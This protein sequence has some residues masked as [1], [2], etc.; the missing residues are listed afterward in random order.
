MKMSCP[1]SESYCVLP[2]TVVI[3]VFPVEDQLPVE[4]SGSHRWL[5]V[6]ET[7]VVYITQAH[8][9][10]S[11]REDPDADLTY[12]ITRPCFSPLRP[13]YVSANASSHAR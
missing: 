3:H 5:T 2:Q 12:E 6:K 11:D 9:H 10:F 13:G 8:L 7:E 1:S 4:V